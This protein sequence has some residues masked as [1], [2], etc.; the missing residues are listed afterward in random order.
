MIDGFMLDN[1]DGSDLRIGMRQFG[2]KISGKFYIPRPGGYAI[3]FDDHRR[4]LAITERG[5]YFLPGGGIES[6]ESAETAVIREAAE[7]TGMKIRIIREIG[8]ANEYV[9][10]PSKDG[11][12]NK[13]GTFYLAAVADMAD[14]TTPGNFPGVVWIL[15]SEFESKAAHQSHVWAIRQAITDSNRAPEADRP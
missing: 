14:Y 2:T 8:C 5:K 3:I 4:I 6:G 11:Y 9:Y 1:G 12:Y 10:A 13:I 7:E 15:I